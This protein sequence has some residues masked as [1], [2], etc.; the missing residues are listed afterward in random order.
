MKKLK[1]LLIYGIIAVLIIAAFGGYI[2][3]NFMGRQAVTAGAILHDGQILSTK[4]GDNIKGLT[5]AQQLDHV[6]QVMTKSARLPD[7]NTVVG[8]GRGS[9]F[10]SV[11]STAVKNAGGLSGIVK[12]GDTVA[13]KVNLCLETENFGSPM[14][15]DYRVTQEV[16]NEVRRCG[17]SKIIVVEGNFN[18][19][20]FL[21]KGNKYCTLNGA[22]LYN[23]NDCDKADCYLLKPEGSLTGTGIY[24]PKLYM[25]ADVV[26]DIAKL[27]THWITGVTLGL[28]NSI[29]VPSYKIYAG[30]GDKDGL[31]ELGIEKVIVD[32]NRIRRPDFVVIDG[33]I[34]GEGYGP[35]E[36]TPVKSNIII[37][38][39]DVVATDTVGLNFMGFKESQIS[40][41]GLAARN[42]VG[43]DDLSKIKIVGADLN[44]IKMK[45]K[46]AV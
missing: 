22:A 27:K 33:I 36:N 39:R 30:S 41:V 38:G 43:I 16:I 17:A 35:T 25:D 31:H 7:K 14:T 12:S 3:Q 23:F 15:T 13:I 24:I 32:I 11:T 21:N 44:S 8:I 18:S 37:A 26:I 45:F 6:K 34:G 4:A 28:K 5:K 1:N 29:G 9:N 19:N 42:K 46:P 20:S 40:H 10:A 2:I